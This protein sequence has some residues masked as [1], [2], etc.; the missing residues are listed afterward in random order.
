[1]RDSVIHPHVHISHVEYFKVKY[2]L[3]Y[4]LTSNFIQNVNPSKFL[5]LNAF[6][7]RKLMRVLREVAYF[8]SNRPHSNDDLFIF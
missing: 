8:R 3:S 1:M 7:P 6:Y 5:T 4:I 2:L